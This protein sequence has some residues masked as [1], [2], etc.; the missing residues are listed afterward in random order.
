MLA[1]LLVMLSFLMVTDRFVDDN[2]DDDDDEDDYEPIKD[3][4]YGSVSSLETGDNMEYEFVVGDNGFSVWKTEMEMN[5]VE[6]CKLYP[7]VPLKDLEAATI[8]LRIYRG[9]ASFQTNPVC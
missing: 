3:G 1:A 4:Y 8:L 6:L 7:M 2:D 5:A 9:W